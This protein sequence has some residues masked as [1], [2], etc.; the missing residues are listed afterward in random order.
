[1]PGVEDLPKLQLLN[2][3]MVETP[4]L[5]EATRYD[6]LTFHAAR[7]YLLARKPRVLYVSFDETDEQAHRGRYDH[8]LDDAHKV[9]G[10]V[11][12]LWELAQSLP[13]YRGKT[14]LVMSTDHG[15]GVGPVDWPDHGQKIPASQVLGIA[16]LGPDTPALGE[17]KNTEVISQGQIAATLASFLGEDYNA[18]QPKAA[19]PLPGVRG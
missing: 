11:R 6:A 2:R 10:Y 3:L 13:E 14:T 18:A 9:D 17:R 4:Q 19:K 1:V 5:G 15:R 8:I 7:E 16:V 12:E